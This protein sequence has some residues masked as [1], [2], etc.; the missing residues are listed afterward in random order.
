MNSER[1]SDPTAEIAVAR[2]MKEN[3]R[4]ERAEKEK[5]ITVSSDYFKKLGVGYGKK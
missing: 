4:K 1:Y 5:P 3:K 2:V